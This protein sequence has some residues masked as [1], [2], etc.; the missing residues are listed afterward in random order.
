V[1]G[2]EE[3]EGTDAPG[4]T[5][6]SEENTSRVKKDSVFLSALERLEEEAD[7]DE[8]EEEEEEESVELQGL[9]GR[10]EAIEE[11]RVLWMMTRRPR[12]RTSLAV[13]LQ[14]TSRSKS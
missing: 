14:G 2:K 9:T 1:G 12:D 7:E 13:P 3:K 6:A 4:L 10:M 8:E 11:W 5:G